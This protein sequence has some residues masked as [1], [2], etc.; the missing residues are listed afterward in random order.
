MK[1]ASYFYYIYIYIFFFAPPSGQ[2]L[3][4]T[5]TMTHDRVSQKLVADCPWHLLRN[6]GPNVNRQ[7]FPLVYKTPQ[8]N[9]QF[10]L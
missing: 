6:E 4:F 2:N 3:S 9:E 5:V 10:D 7:Y 8:P 1:F